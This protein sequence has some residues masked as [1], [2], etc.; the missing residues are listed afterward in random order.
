MRALILLESLVVV[1]L[2][3]AILLRGP[4]ELAEAEGFLAEK[5]ILDTLRPDERV[6]YRRDDGALLEFRVDG[7]VHREGTGP[8]RIPIRRTF[9]AAPG[10]APDP[11]APLYVHRPEVHGLFPFLAADDPTA[12]DRVW[13]WRR[14]TRAEIQVG[15]RRT[16]CWRVDC[17]DPA[18]PEGSDAVA[19][20]M[21]PAVPLYGILRFER[22]GHA[23]ELVAS[24][25][26]WR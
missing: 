15:D 5:M 18:L 1:G 2:A 8:P 3:L 7:Q 26:A 12:L 9:L 24:N 20:W 4:A 19:V 11:D 10:A 25:P 14:V 22:Q 13:I 17:I 23:Y 16:P 6:T 21:D